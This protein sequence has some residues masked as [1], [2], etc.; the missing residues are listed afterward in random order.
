LRD[1]QSRGSFIKL[2]AGFVGKIQARGSIFRAVVIKG[3]LQYVGASEHT[4]APG[5]YFNSNEEFAHHI[6]STE[7]EVVLYVRTD[8]EFEVIADDQ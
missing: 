3:Q 8:V 5:S 2:P 7:T 1:G 4:L 6:A